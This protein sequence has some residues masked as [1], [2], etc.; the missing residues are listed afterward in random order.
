MSGFNIRKIVTQV[1]EILH[2]GG[3]LANPAPVKGAIYA[4]CANP[5]SR[6]HCN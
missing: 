5:S 1:E 3:P 6:W 2:E 4:I